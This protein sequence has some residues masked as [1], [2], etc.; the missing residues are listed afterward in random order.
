MT[1]WNIAATPDRYVRAFDINTGKQLWSADLP[2]SAHAT[3]LTYRLR[4]DSKQLLVIAA[5]GHVL[6]DPG[7]AIVAFALE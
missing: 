1:S 7:D 2:F 3:P 5:G 4:P 6:S